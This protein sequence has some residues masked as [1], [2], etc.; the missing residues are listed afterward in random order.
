MTGTTQ[1]NTALSAMTPLG[2][3][4]LVLHA[5]EG[6]EHVGSLFHFRLTLSTDDMTVDLSPVI[7]QPVTVTLTGPDGAD[8]KSVV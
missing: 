1:D 4:K 5:F 7:G 2:K 8:R 3:D 6:E